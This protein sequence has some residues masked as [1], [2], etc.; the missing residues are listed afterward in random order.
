MAPR[1]AL[2]VLNARALTIYLWHVPLIIAVV[3]LAEV[4][5]LPVHGWVG[6]TWRLAVVSVLLGVVVLAVG[7]VEDLSAGRRPALVPGRMR[8]LVPVSPAPA[9][10]GGLGAQKAA[11][12]RG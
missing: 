12:R 8:R 4:T 10:A 7:W 3:R 5:G 1:R 11:A 9:G 2:T 6:I